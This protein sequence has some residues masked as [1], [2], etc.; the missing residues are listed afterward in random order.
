MTR[1]A[2][3]KLC[4]NGL[5]DIVTRA[6]PVVLGPLWIA[7]MDERTT[8][9]SKAARRDASGVNRLARFAIVGAI[10]FLADAA[11]LAIVLAATPL[12]PFAGRVVSVA[13]ALTVTWLL[14]RRFTFGASDRATA[15]E[16]VRYGGVGIATS[17]VNYLVYTALLVMVPALSPLL[18]LATASVAAM[19]L[20]FLGYSRFVFGRRSA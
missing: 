7:G 13:F 6:D 1:R 18:A 5:R 11:A 10:G 12:G 4:L 14:N 15:V 8:R 2:G 16:G 17:V 3:V 19:A 20:S 9:V